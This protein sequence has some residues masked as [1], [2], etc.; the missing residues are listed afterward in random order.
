MEQRLEQNTA[1]CRTVDM[2]EHIGWLGPEW[3]GSAWA[4]NNCKMAETAGPWLVD[5]HRT[6]GLEQLNR[7]I[8]PVGAGH[9]HTGV[10]LEELMPK[11]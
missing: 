7:N 6:S 4:G 9:I 8:G 1:G 3:S 5:M 2:L 11:Q 10:S